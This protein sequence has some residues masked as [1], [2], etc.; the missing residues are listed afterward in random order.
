MNTPIK[1][2]LN[3]I[4]QDYQRGWEQAQLEYMRQEKQNYIKGIKPTF[5]NRISIH[6]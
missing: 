2:N 3:S 5:T 1:N 6:S 4:A